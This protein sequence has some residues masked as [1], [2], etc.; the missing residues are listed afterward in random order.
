MLSSV[1]AEPY[2]VA[3]GFVETLFV[4]HFLEEIGHAVRA[5]VRREIRVARAFALSLS[6]DEHIIELFVREVTE[7]PRGPLT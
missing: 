1:E 5:E 4:K 3:S 6:H 7:K 2:E